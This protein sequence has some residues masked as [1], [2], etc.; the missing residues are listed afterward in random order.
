M[1]IIKIYTDG[2]YKPK[3]KKGSIAFLII[4]DGKMIQEYSRAI[5]SDDLT[6]TAMELYAILKALNWVRS[7]NLSPKKHIVY[8]YTDSQQIQL[9]LSSWM[10]KWKDNNWKNSRNKPIKYL[11]LWKKI[12]DMIVS[13]FYDFH[14]QW[15]EGHVGDSN[16]SRVDELCRIAMKDFVKSTINVELS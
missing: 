9:G 15:I 11:N 6:N 14:P 2:G 8:L 5:T 1:K 3:L 10:Y 13:E 4:K 12:Y 16:N 7:N